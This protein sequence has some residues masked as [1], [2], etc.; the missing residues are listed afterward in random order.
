MIPSSARQGPCQGPDQF[1]G[2]PKCWHW[3][4]W[5]A[6]MLGSYRLSCM[7]TVTG[8]L[9]VGACGRGCHSMENSQT[10]ASLQFSTAVT[11][12]L[13]HDDATVTGAAQTG[14]CYDILIVRDSFTSVNPGD[15]QAPISPPGNAGL[16]CSSLFMGDVREYS[17]S[18]QRGSKACCVSCSSL[19]TAVKLL[20]ICADRRGEPSLLSPRGRSNVSHSIRSRHPDPIP[21]S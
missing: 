21:L 5:L 14:E 7:D 3:G 17:L 6:G 12:Y 19:R 13:C 15:Q 8:I 10:P 18:P 9:V 16:C 20:L 2:V 4:L 11:Q 1:P